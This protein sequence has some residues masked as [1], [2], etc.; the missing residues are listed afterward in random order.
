MVGSEGELRVTNPVA[1]HFFNRLTVRSPSG[2]RSERVKGDATYTYQLSAFVEHVRG[3]RR[4]SSVA[5]EGV[6]TMRVI[7]A[8]YEKSGLGRRGT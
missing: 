4:M 8:V 3:G 2:A 5:R 7:D 1:P 6:R